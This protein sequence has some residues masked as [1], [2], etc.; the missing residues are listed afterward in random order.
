MAALAGDMNYKLFSF[1]TTL[2]YTGRRFTTS[3]NSSWLD[4]YIL[5]NTEVSQGFRLHSYLLKTF[6]RINNLLDTNY[7]SVENRPM[8]LRNITVGI[9]ITFKKHEL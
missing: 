7:R 2:N 3:D 6:L 5:V 9:C 4:D 8:P 1:R